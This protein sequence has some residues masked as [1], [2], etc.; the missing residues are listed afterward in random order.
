[1]GGI[2]SHQNKLITIIPYDFK[3][4]SCDENTF[5]IDDE[6]DDEFSARFTE[7]QNPQ[8]LSCKTNERPELKLDLKNIRSH[9]Y[10]YLYYNFKN[11]ISNK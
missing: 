8:D 2:I 6:I 1:M 5:N 3:K 11:V 9:K 7:K 10:L 4:I